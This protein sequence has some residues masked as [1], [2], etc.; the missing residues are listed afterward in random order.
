[1]DKIE[2]QLV[3]ALNKALINQDEHPLSNSANREVKKAEAALNVYIS[4]ITSMDE[5]Y[6]SPETA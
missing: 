3:K 4:D 5:N 2:K 1:M 6:F